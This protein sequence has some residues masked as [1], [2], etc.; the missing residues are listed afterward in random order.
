MLT[1]MNKIEFSQE[2]NSL[3][4]HCYSLIFTSL[5]HEVYGSIGFSFFTESLVIDLS[6]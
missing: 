5:L 2:L 6:S 3:L 4:N 1:K